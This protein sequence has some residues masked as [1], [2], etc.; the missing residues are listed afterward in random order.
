CIAVTL[1][2]SASFARQYQSPKI[3]GAEQ[4]ASSSIISNAIVQD[5]KGFIWTG[6]ENGLSK[7]DG[8]TFTIYKSKEGDPTSI[9]NNIITALYIDST[10]RLW[11]ASVSGLQYYDEEEDNFKTDLRLSHPLLQ[12]NQIKTLFE[13]SQ[14]NLWIA[15][16]EQGVLKYSLQTGKYKMYISGEDGKKVNGKS[17]RTILEDQQGNIWFATIDKGL[18][19][20]MPAEDSFKYYHSTNSNLPVDA[21]LCIELL[22]NNKLL[23]STIGH[24]IYIL[25]QA[26]QQIV[27]VGINHLS[28]FCM[29]RMQD[30]TVLVGTDGNGLWHIDATGKH[31]TRHTAI[32]PEMHEV[33]SGKMHSL[34]EDKNGNIWIGMYNEGICYIRRQP[35]GFTAYKRR[36]NQQNSLSY[37]QVTGIATDPD[38]NIWFATDGG[39]LN[40]YDRKNDCYTHFK[41]IPN[42]P[43]SLPD[44]AVVSVICDKKGTIWAGT[45]TGGLSKYD[46]TTK[47][48]YTYRHIGV[49]GGLPGNYMKSIV[50]DAR[51]NF[52][53]GLDGDGISYFDPEK[54]TFTNYTI[55]DG[56]VSNYVTHLHL[57]SSGTLWIGTHKGLSSFD[58]EQQVFRNYEESFN[59]TPL[60]IYSI[61]EDTEQVIWI[62][63]SLGLYRYNAGND[64][65]EEEKLP[66]ASYEQLVINSIVPY[67]RNLWLT[68][69]QGILCYEPIA[70]QILFSINNNDMEGI[71]FIRSA[72][73]ISPGNEL[74]LGGGN[75]CFSFYPDS[76][77]FS[78]YTAKTYITELKISNQP[79]RVGEVYNGRV[80][81]PKTLDKTDRILLKHNENNLTFHFAAP[82]SLLPA[83]THYVC[84]M[85]GVDKAWRYFDAGQ[86]NIT[87]A[88]LSH[89]KY[90]FHVYATHIPG[91][92]DKL[93]TSLAL[94]ILP[95]LWLTWWAKLIYLILGVLLSFMVFWFIYLRMKYQNELAME[96][97]KAREQEELN[98][99]KM[100]FF[101]N[102]SL[103]SA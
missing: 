59:Y 2:P 4:G 89:G 28:S 30:H 9:A 8:H 92:P 16:E 68:T 54:E 66:L 70:G 20:Y 13:D 60:S 10:D 1:Y 88:N 3:L 63:S 33:T 12:R 100:Q 83:S 34:L 97:L 85:E 46:P 74:F 29:R 65:F 53:L 11:V 45:Y 80:I 5:S 43:G 7:F 19:V 15:V 61:V 38:N 98:R 14:H 91:Q 57:A 87:Y 90:V 27:P 31:I 51:G 21:L 72:C 93:L 41:T 71:S 84:K 18:S 35:T 73:Y 76:I 77:D 96:K 32:P 23:I 37:G 95:P 75:G 47:R 99:N 44:N 86:T 56:L 17:V 50:E 69:N 81:L 101:T 55:S 62:G 25:D 36:Y 79:V 82:T 49:P 6:T 58:T 48:F 40:F 52:W 103:N 42:D 26:T 64:S 22:A 67:K 39:G 24:G 78:S 94:Q 102:I